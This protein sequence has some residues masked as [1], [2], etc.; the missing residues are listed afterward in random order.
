MLS[1]DLIEKIEIDLFLEGIYKVWG[2]DLR[3]YSRPHLNRRLRQWKKEM[4]HSNFSVAQSSILH[5]ADHFQRFINAITVN[6]TSMFRDTDFYLNLRTKIIPH[7]KSH[8]FCKI[9]IAGCASGEE[10]YSI[11]ILLNEEGLKNH[12]RIY[13]TDINLDVL[14]KAREGIFTQHEIK[15]FTM[16]YQK[17]GG[18][19]HFSDYYSA[20]Y[21]HAIMHQSLRDSI[22]FA[23]HNLSCDNA[24]GEMQLI[25]CR[26]VLIY[27]DSN[28]AERALNLFDDSLC[29]GGFLGLG[30]NEGIEQRSINPRFKRIDHHVALY[31][32]KYR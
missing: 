29:A 27:F 32:K 4:G 6:V 20:H 23:Q 19:G 22:V 24:F 2:V 28:L 1:P 17:A 11:A 31:Q 15:R 25:L 3:T 8:P 9:W 13:A 5:D 7:L 16:A 10:A 14:Q 21:G 26:N 30:L 18:N 12:F